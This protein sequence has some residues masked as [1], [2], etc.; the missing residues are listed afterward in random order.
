MGANHIRETNMKEI[1]KTDPNK[2]L[3]FYQNQVRD[4]IIFD[5]E[6]QNMVSL[7]KMESGCVIPIEKKPRMN[8]SA[9]N[10]PVNV[11]DPNTAVVN[12]ANEI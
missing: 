5:S 10:T 11:I 6:D 9:Y 1:L 2:V 7:N 8:M 3:E 4:R 12:Q